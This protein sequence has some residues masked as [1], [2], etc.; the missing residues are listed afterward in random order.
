MAA[1]K[2]PATKPAAKTWQEQRGARFGRGAAK[3]AP[4]DPTPG[5]HTPGKTFTAPS[6]KHG[7][8]QWVYK[9]T[10]SGKVNPVR[11]KGAKPAA[12]TDTSSLPT[13]QALADASKPYGEYTDAI[14]RSADDQFAGQE[15]QARAGQGVAE[16]HQRDLEVV[17]DRFKNQLLGQDDALRA[18]QN[19][20]LANQAAV[21][22]SALTGLGQAVGQGAQ[23]QAAVDQQTGTNYAGDVARVGA[24]GAAGAAAVAQPKQD[25][26]VKTAGVNE[27]LMG[28][29][30]TLMDVE[31]QRQ[32]GLAAQQ[33]QDWQTK[34]IDIS[35]KKGAEKQADYKDR[36]ATAAK[37]LQQQFDNELASATLLSDK[38][39]IKKDFE[40]KMADVTA[41]MKIASG[42]NQT[43]KT[44][45]GIRAGAT[46][47]AATIGAGG[48]TD[49]ARIR[50]DAAKETARI[51]ADAKIKAQR[52]SGGKNGP[53]GPA[54][55]HTADGKTYTMSEADRKKWNDRRRLAIDT[56]LSLT[57]AMQS[58]RD[59]SK[60]IKRVKAAHSGVPANVIAGMINAAKGK[61]ATAQQR[62]A[63]RT[64]FP[65]GIIP[66]G[67]IEGKVVR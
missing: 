31:R 11:A 63:L 47:D 58:E 49:A 27:G 39:K 1:T 18:N 34:R 32:G 38:Q 3:P 21:Q 14:N 16:Q 26:L 6:K 55:L 9:T 65:G 13:P 66:P 46:T 7:G 44:V 59:V 10:A 5:Q 12:K 37:A 20:A 30:G 15:A 17:Y 60:A 51:A 41:K 67:F 2:P 45:A 62:V 50:A 56:S 42:L 35:G 61:P 52:I 48:T 64:F 40:A 54:T 4:P 29:L 36:L 43:A 23:Q 28:S 24:A 19:A 8:K 53:K 57:R 33:V 25:A 22:T